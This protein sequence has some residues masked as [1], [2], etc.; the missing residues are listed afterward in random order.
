[1]PQKI[2][3]IGTSLGVIIPKDSAKQIGWKVGD[4]VNVRVNKKNRGINVLPAEEVSGMDERIMRHALQFIERY[5]KDL[6][7]L[8]KK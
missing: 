1:M 8:A 2:V 4:F 3:K 7:A 5:R 6:E